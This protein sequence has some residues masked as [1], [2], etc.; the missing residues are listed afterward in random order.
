MT[1]LN[2]LGTM[3]ELFSQWR[4]AHRRESDTSYLND[5]IPKDMFLPDGV[6]DPV[7]FSA[8]RPRV[9]FLAKEA[10][11]FA[12][13]AGAPPEGAVGSF[14]HQDVAFGRA[15]K[16]Q[17]SYRLAMLA[18]A[19]LHSDRQHYSVIDQDHE[20]LRSVAV[21]NLN[22]RG[23]YA[24]CVWHTLNTY[25]KRYQ[26][27]IRRQISLIAPDLIICCGFD[28]KWLLDEYDLAP[29]CGQVVWVYHPS[30][31]AISNANYLNQLRCAMTGEC[32]V[33]TRSLRCVAGTE[34]Q[35][36]GII[37]DTYSPL[38][39]KEML[40]C[41]KI[42][43]YGEAAGTIDS[44]RRNDCAL[45]SVRGMG[46]VAAGR[47]ISDTEEIRRDGTLEKFRSVAFL[48]PSA[49]QIPHGTE[50]L[51]GLPWREV[52]QLL[53]HGFF[54][55]RTDKRPYLSRE[56]CQVLLNALKKRYI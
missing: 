9:L 27:Y 52:K 45:F 53:G 38:S 1:E 8:A 25:V 49:E 21:V 41:S 14:W 33:P 37:F 31:F 56:E 42:S 48:V 30:Y 54:H 24:Y 36:K 47:V 22:K 15:D 43:A 20:V 7:R 39:T 55:A 18:N 34:P 44:L 17:F 32:W 4:E 23:G 13:G 19:V 50:N 2:R 35:E 10:N 5:D 28:V 46:I 16:T 3:E 51:R 29:G 26:D 6:I 11:W 40:L 12:P